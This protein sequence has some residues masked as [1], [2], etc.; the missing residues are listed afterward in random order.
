MYDSMTQLQQSNEEVFES[1][2]KIAVRKAE[3]R[4]NQ[5]EPFQKRKKSA[6]TVY[7]GFNL[8]HSYSNAH[9]FDAMAFI[10]KDQNVSNVP[11]N[12]SHSVAN[13]PSAS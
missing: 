3:L 7:S 9:E 1:F 12:W 13:L 4:S 5:R 8:R 2:N 6:N 11:S 10:D